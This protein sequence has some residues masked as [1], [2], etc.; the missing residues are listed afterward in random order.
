MPAIGQQY[1]ELYNLNEWIKSARK[2]AEAEGESINGILR[3]A[4]SFLNEL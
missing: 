3:E 4:Q 2:E 1:T